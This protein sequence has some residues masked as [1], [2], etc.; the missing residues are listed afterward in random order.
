MGKF[1]LQLVATLDLARESNV[2]HTD[3]H[4][5]ETEYLVKE[6]IPKQ[7]KAEKKYTP[8]QSRPLRA[9]SFGADPTRFNELD[10]ALVDWGVS[11]SANMHLTEN[12]QPV[13]LRAPE[14]LIR[15]PWDTQVDWWNLGAVV[16]EVHRAVGLFD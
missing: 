7:D 15:A 10:I 3:V 2:I 8:I 13:A 9:C 5:I 1:T 14:V 6:P 11:S 12:I 16:F 4:R